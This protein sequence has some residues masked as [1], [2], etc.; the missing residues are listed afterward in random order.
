[1]EQGTKVS[2]EVEQVSQ[3]WDGGVKVNGTWYNGTKVTANYVK[4][5]QKGQTVELT[6]DDRNKIMFLKS[7]GA[8]SPQAPPA[9]PAGNGTPSPAPASE[10]DDY[11][12]AKDMRITRMAALNTSLEMVKIA[13]QNGGF[14]NASDQAKSVSPDTVFSTAAALAENF[15]IPWI[16][17]AK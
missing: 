7:N 15:V 3:K 2:G 12:A 4:G 8:P 9:Q 6:L 16:L 13:V 17:K 11:W 10:K 5:C 14:A 1:M